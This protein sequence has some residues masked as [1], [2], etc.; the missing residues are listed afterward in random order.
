MQKIIKIV[1]ENKNLVVGLLI[2]IMLLVIGIIISFA[3]FNVIAETNIF[4]GKTKYYENPDLNI[5][6]MVE[7][8]ND[9]GNANGTYTAYWNAPVSGYTYN[10][11]KSNCTNGATFT[12]NAVDETFSV[13][14]KG[15]T[16]CEFYYDA[17]GT[18][19]VPDSSVTVYKQTPDKSEYILA[20]DYKI[21]TLL[22]GGYELNESKSTCQNGSIEVDH[23]N[24]EIITTATQV[25]NCNAYFDLGTSEYNYTGDYQV[26]TALTS[27]TYKFETWGASGS[28]TYEYNSKGAYNAGEIYLEK[29]ETFYIYVGEYGDRI[30]RAYNGGGAAYTSVAGSGGGATDIRIIPGSWD[31]ALGLNSRIMVSGAGGGGSKNYSIYDPGYAGGLIGDSGYATSY[32]AYTASGGTQTSGGVVNN[33]NSSYS[34]GTNGTFGIG[35]NGGGSVSNG[36]SSG[37]GGYYGGAGGS[38]LL[39]GSWPGGGGSSFISGHTGAVAI[40]SETDQ[41]PRG[42]DFDIRYIEIGSN[43]SDK[44]TYNHITEMQAYD[45]NGNNVALN[46]T[47]TT[48]NY[49]EASSKPYSN[50]LD[51]TFDIAANYAGVGTSTTV[52]LGTSY[53]LSSVKLW[54]YYGDSRTYYETYVKVYNEDKT[55]WAYIHNY[56]LDG[57]YAETADGKEMFISCTIGT[58]DKL[59]SHHYSGY[60]FDNTVM[61][62][63]AGY[64]WT[65]VKGSQVAM[66]NPSGGTYALGEG[67][68]GHGYAK[69]TYMG[70]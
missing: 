19:L 5:K 35:G 65:N 13:S 10:A 63:G 8:R 6:Y 15:K 38:R 37:G 1:K 25:S 56:E 54:R 16:T 4:T 41:S 60:I 67:H 36:S 52:D 46:K 58:T 32:I 3:Y 43:G 47:L 23:I 40:K 30:I 50:A 42:I 55:K 34:A 33:Y 27:G 31:T 28:G 26:F 9:E 24:K 17:E 29:G 39:S 62:D 68:T 44:N 22:N 51:G 12:R 64:N 11:E 69:I 53:S 14:S 45:I 57:T 18:S 49:P 7:N 61:I 70:E 66:P 48:I 59:C 2:I 20:N 21:E